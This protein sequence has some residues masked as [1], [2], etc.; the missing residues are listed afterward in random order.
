MAQSTPSH[1]RTGL[2]RILNDRGMTEADLARITGIAQS[3]INRIKNGRV[4]P[5]VATA[6]H[7]AA[8]LGCTVEDCF[9]D[10]WMSPRGK[11]ASRAA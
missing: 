10:A 4:C 8:V 9:A 6:L 5:R 11:E 1:R 7:I 2:V 3:R